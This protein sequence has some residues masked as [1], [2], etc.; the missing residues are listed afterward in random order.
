MEFTLGRPF[1]NGSQSG[2][3]S[4]VMLPPVAQYANRYTINSHAGFSNYLTIFAAPEHFQPN[5][6]FLDGSSLQ[7]ASWTPV[8]CDD[9]SVCGYITRLN[10]TVGD[11]NL[12]HA[13]A[14]GRVGVLV[15]G[16]G[17]RRFR[18]FMSYAYPGGLQIG[19]HLN[20]MGI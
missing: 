19:K 6:I 7:D 16:H 3:P 2:D 5:E 15:Y 9:G 18:N 12:T 14:D 4:M 8:N 17:F 20:L 1:R 11:H 10:V 13:G